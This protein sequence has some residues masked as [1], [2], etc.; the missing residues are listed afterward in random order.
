MVSRSRLTSAD[1]A[2]LI[3]GLTAPSFRVMLSGR[4]SHGV[5]HGF[6]GTLAAGGPPNGVTR[7]GSSGIDFKY[8]T[9]AQRWSSVSSGPITPLPRGPDLARTSRKVGSV[10]EADVAIFHPQVYSV[11]G[12]APILV[13]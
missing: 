9:S 8:S 7:P 5:C 1:G 11:R 13:T 12:M 10:P 4:H 2:P 3:S 6:C